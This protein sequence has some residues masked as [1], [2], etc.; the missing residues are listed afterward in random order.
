LGSI[1]TYN[2]AGVNPATGRPMWLDSARNLTYQVVA[3]DRVY[4]GDNQP[5]FFGGWNN[6]ISY[7]G[8]SLEAFFNYEYGRLAQDGQ[9][10]FLTEN[11]ARLNL[12]QDVYDLRWTTPGQLTSWPRM[13]ATG[14]ESKGSG[15][16]TGD[17]A[18]FKADY[19]RLKNVTLSYDLPASVYNRLRLSSARFYVSGTNLYTFADTRSYDVEFFGASTGI[20]PQSKIFQAGVQIGF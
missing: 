12:L 14:A 5:E 3:K 17:R 8:F 15:A 6:S 2:Y 11:L 20:I 4:I 13:N 19:V 18:W 1:F 9:V 7:G 16:Q 10:L